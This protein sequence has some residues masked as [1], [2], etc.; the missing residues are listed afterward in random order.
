MFQFSHDCQLSAGS[1]FYNSAPTNND[2]VHILVCV[3]PADISFPLSDEVVKMIQE[4]RLDAR[5]L[6]EHKS[7]HLC[8]MMSSVRCRSMWTH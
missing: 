1:R 3:F 6:G 2:K 5:D 8:V 7:L 4:I